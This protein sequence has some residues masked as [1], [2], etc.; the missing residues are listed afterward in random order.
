M[1]EF[2]S[3]WIKWVSD[4]HQPIVIPI[5]RR[6]LGIL[7]MKER[8]ICSNPSI[9][10][11]TSNW[12][13][14]KISNTN[15]TDSV[16]TNFVKRLKGMWLHLFPKLKRINKDYDSLTI[17]VR[18]TTSIC[19]RASIQMWPTGKNEFL[20]HMHEQPTRTVI[21]STKDM[22]RLVILRP[23]YAW[24]YESCCELLQINQFQVSNILVHKSWLLKSKFT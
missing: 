2:R 18:I 20:D 6:S 16:Q 4:S 10:C 3:N 24:N 19:T 5:Q 1:I 21:N 17:G 22:D 15:Q 13:I 7:I 23:L 11:L 9:N 8:S 12:N 14:I